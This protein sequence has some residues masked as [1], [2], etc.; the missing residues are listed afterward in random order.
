M[1]RKHVEFKKPL[2][3][4]RKF[5]FSLFFIILTSSF[6]Y[7][8]SLYLFIPFVLF[9]IIY[10]HKKTP[11]LNRLFYEY[12]T[13]KESKFFKDN[14]YIYVN[15][16]DEYCGF[17]KNKIHNEKVIY[18]NE[19]SEDFYYLDKKIDIHKRISV[20]RE[21]YYDYLVKSDNIDIESQFFNYIC[22]EDIKGINTLLKEEKIRIKYIHFTLAAQIRVKF[23]TFLVLFNNGKKEFSDDNVYSFLFNSFVDK[24]K[25]LSYFLIDYVLKNIS[26]QH[27]YI[28]N[29]ISI[30]FIYKKNKEAYLLLDKFVEDIKFFKHDCES[31][32]T[33]FYDNNLNNDNEIIK[34]FSYEDLINGLSDVFKNDKFQHIDFED[35]KEKARLYNQINNF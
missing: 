34:M 4:K 8:Y 30:L 29:L 32:F 26:F 21:H 18:L 14:Y 19:D 28:S 6:F 9:E 15:H 2:F 1:S 17:Y 12:K 16:L 13:K 20:Y 24:N 33:V 25:E 23:D 22:N 7:S 11:K 31:I 35:Y 10:G 27:E 5:S 3:N